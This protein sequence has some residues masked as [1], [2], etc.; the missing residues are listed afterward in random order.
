METYNCSIHLTNE[1]FDED[2]DFILQ[3]IYTIDSS[4]RSKHFGLRLTLA[5]IKYFL[6]NYGGIKRPYSPWNI[7]TGFDLWDILPRGNLW[8][9]AFI[10]TQLGI[11]LKYQMDTS[12]EVEC[13]TWQY[14][15][16]HDFAHAFANLMIETFRYHG[17]VFVWEV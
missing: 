5:H 12:F 17:I 10:E 8:L 2:L 9:H 13:A 6:Y 14:N 16:D 1:R 4:M 15:D 3:A 11:D 7:Y